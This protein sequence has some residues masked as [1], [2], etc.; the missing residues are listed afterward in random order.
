MGIYALCF[1][2]L[3]GE[4]KVEW[5]LIIKVVVGVREIEENY[6]IRTWNGGEG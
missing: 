3:K 1:L 4:R 2:D 5:R 6:I